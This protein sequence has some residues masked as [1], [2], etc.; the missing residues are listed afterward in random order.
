MPWK[1][2]YAPDHAE[3]DFWGRTTGA[4]IFDAKHEFF[5]HRFERGPL[6]VLCDFTAVE[7]FD[8]SPAEVRHIVEQDRRYA[9]VSPDLLEAVVA[10][11]PL[12]YGMSRM[13]EIQVGEAR[14]RTA[15]RQTRSEVLAWLR[16]KGVVGVSPVVS[17]AGS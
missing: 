14:P 6:W 12:E 16:E 13:W 1:A 17:T 10:P 11:G 2:H 8:V 15:V 3:L 4:E 5:H 9:P 7:E